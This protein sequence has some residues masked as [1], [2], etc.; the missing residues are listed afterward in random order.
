MIVSLAAI[1]AASLLHVGPPPHPPQLPMHKTNLIVN[2]DFSAGNSGF[3]SGYAFATPISAEGQYTIGTDPCNDAPPQ[4]V[5]AC[6][7]DHTTGAGNMLE[8]DGFPNTPNVAV[9]SETIPVT[10]QTTYKFTFW[11]AGVDTQGN[12]SPAVLQISFNG[13]AAKHL[14]TLP[15]VW[16]SWVR[17]HATWKSRGATEVTISLVDTNVG[18]P[19]NDF[20]LD[21]LSFMPAKK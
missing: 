1:F 13:V 17:Y 15:A 7:G 18:G 11:G 6:F 20:A 21:D 16:T 8:A 14:A 12:S 9:W 4:Y 2:G 5:W 19:F 10:P 3:T